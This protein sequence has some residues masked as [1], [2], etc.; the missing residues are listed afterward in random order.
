MKLENFLVILNES[1]KT[2]K[3]ILDVFF[4]YEKNLYITCFF[5]NKPFLSFI[6]TSCNSVDVEFLHNYE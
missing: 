3:V 5:V 4:I 2:S 6:R 1:K